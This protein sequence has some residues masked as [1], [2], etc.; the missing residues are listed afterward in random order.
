MTRHLA[1][2][3]IFAIRDQLAAH[4]DDPERFELVNINGLISALTTPFQVT[5]GAES[6]PSVIDK[7]GA[8]T[9]LLIANHPFQDGNKRV[10]AR[11]LR[12]FL[13]RNG[14]LLHASPAEEQHFTM[15]LT[16]ARLRDARITAWIARHSTPR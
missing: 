6:F 2:E 12:L 1:L 11:A 10:A 14:L 8:L 7:A 9:F 16:H 13:E 3:D 15:L 5:F 4:A